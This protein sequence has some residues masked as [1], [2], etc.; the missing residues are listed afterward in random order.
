MAA[1]DENRSPFLQRDS[2]SAIRH[3]AGRLSHDFN[4]LLTP[5]LAYPQLV[6]KDLAPDSSARDLLA[7]MEKTADDMAHITT[8]LARFS[9]VS[10]AP[11]EPVHVAG[12]ARSAIDSI[13]AMAAEQGIEVSVRIVDGLPDVTVIGAA[14]LSL[15]LSAL[16]SNAVEAMGTGGKL[17]L[18]ARQDSLAGGIPVIGSELAAGP[19][20]VITVSDT[21]VGIDAATMPKIFDPFYTTRRARKVRGSGLGLIIVYALLQD[22]GGGVTVRSAAGGGSAFEIYLPLHPVSVAQREEVSGGATASSDAPDASSGASPSPRVLVCD[23]EHVIVEL[24]RMMIDSAIEGVEVDEAAHGL[25]AV[26][27][28]EA[29]RHAVIIMDLHMPV[30]DGHTAF[31][32]LQKL[33]DANSWPMPVMIFCTGYAPPDGVRKIVDAGSRHELLLKPVTCAKLISAVKSGL[34]R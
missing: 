10:P 25:E 12:V 22:A 33:C 23:D 31:R 17:E 28:F 27:L 20:V 13:A 21:G 14:Q 9:L 34:A 4:N 32:T 6:R 11:R 5:L 15:V 7:V 26:Q 2:L 29:R 19:Y 24:F 8:Q 3:V 16:L 30:M 1:H 18:A